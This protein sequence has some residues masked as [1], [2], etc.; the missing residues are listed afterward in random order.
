M[1]EGHPQ[2]DILLFSGVSESLSH[3]C[4]HSPDKNFGLKGYFATVDHSLEKRGRLS[5]ERDLPKGCQNPQ[6]LIFTHSTMLSDRERIYSFMSA[7]CN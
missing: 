5:W 6:I 3:G 1:N 2:L 7:L 4:I